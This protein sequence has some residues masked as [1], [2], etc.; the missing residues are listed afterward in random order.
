MNVSELY[1]WVL[2]KWREREED[3]E[4][5]LPLG[6]YSVYIIVPDLQI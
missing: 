6:G 4:A 1:L 2:V 3:I 5:H